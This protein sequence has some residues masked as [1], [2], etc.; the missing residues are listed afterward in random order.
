MSNIILAIDLRKYKSFFGW[1][2]IIIKHAAFRTV[3][4]TPTL[5]DTEIFATAGCHCADRDVFA[6]G[7][8]SCLL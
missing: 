1:F 3:K 2:D 4:T 6:G 8:G 7:V 5:F